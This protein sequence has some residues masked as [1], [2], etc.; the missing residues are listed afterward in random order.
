MGVSLS[1]WRDKW[2]TMQLRSRLII[3]TVLLLIGATAALFIVRA[4]AIGHRRVEVDALQAQQAQI[5][6]EIADLK[7]LLAKE[8][9]PATMEYLARLKLGMVKPGETQYLLVEGDHR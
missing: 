7:A 4:V 6:Q 8:N 5:T 2:Q 3:I 9:D 1:A